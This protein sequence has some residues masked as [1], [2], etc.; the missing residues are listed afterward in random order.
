VLVETARRISR[1]VRETDIFGRY[2][3]EEFLIV[4]PFLDEEHMVDFGERVRRSICDQPFQ[5][6]GGSI[7]V[8][9]SIG[10]ANTL[11]HGYA[12][13]GLIRAADQRLY[14]AKGKEIAPGNSVA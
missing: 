3:G 9:I 8:S 13:D 10:A 5:T 6:A 7:P 12:M 2:G 1:V 11:H 4:S 14:E